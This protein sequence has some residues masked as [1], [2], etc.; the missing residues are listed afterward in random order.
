MPKSKL[1]PSSY[2]VVLLSFC[3]CVADLYPTK[4]DRFVA[5]LS[6]RCFPSQS[7]YLLDSLHIYREFAFQTTFQTGQL[8]D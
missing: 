7:F 1:Y 2:T 3:E 4:V 8:P 5:A 6:K